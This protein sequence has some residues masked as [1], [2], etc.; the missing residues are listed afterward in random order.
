MR[1]T[2]VSNV[3]VGQLGGKKP[4]EIIG[5]KVMKTGPDSLLIWT[6]HIWAE[7]TILNALKTTVDPTTD[8]VFQE[9]PNTN[10]AIVVVGQK[11]Y[12]ETKGDNLSLSLPTPGPDF[13]NNVCRKVECVVVPNFRPPSGDGTTSSNHGLLSLHG[14]LEVKGQEGVAD[15]LFGDYRSPES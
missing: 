3:V 13:I 10:F 11:P 2:W 6:L 9:N 15:V 1:K 4:V 12:A 5:P 8:V 7:T 14:S